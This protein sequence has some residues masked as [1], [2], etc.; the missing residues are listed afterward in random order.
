[1]SEELLRSDTVNCALLSFDA[2]RSAAS[3]ASELEQETPLIASI[4]EG[5]RLIIAVDALLDG[6]ETVVAERLSAI[7]RRG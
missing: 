2:G 5:D 7:L 1:M 4:V 6:Q 3:V